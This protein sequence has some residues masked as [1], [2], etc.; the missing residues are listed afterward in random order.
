[1]PSGGL[2]NR[3]TIKMEDLPEALS[4]TYIAKDGQRYDAGMIFLKKPDLVQ[5][6]SNL[7]WKIGVDFGTSATMLYFVDSNGVP[8]PLVI[9]P[10]LFQIMNSG[11]ARTSTVLNFIASESSEM[12]LA[13]VIT[14]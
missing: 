9:N 10:H 4:F 1:M 3:F 11:D 2:A 8:K 14:V 7:S 12:L 6:Q 5:P 13:L